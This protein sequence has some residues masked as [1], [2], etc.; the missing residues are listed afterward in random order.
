M[1]V[2]IVTIACALVGILSSQVGSQPTKRLIHV[3]VKQRLIIPPS[4]SR[5]RAL[6]KFSPD[7]KIFKNRPTTSCSRS[8]DTEQ[9]PVMYHL[10]KPLKLHDTF[11]VIMKSKECNMRS[12]SISLM[13]ENNKT[14]C[15][16]KII[17]DDKQSEPRQLK[18]KVLVEEGPSTIL[19]PLNEFLQD[20]NITVSF[21][22]RR[23]V[24]TSENNILEIGG[25]SSSI[26]A[27]EIDEDADVGDITFLKIVGDGWD[28]AELN[29]KFDLIKEP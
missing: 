11:D 15:T 20:S 16:L 6:S 27:M 17:S 13:T 14:A 22:V 24:L 19:W 25:K 8:C 1:A 5:S 10:P 9:T 4:N 3:G 18:H 29:F 28:V 12:L 21:T 2:L 23:N 7:R 26:T